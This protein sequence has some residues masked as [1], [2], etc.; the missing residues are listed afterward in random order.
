MPSTP[1]SELTGTAE[2]PIGGVLPNSISGPPSGWRLG[3]WSLIVTQFQGAFNDNALKF[4][5]IY[6]I[7]ER[8]FP[9]AMR[10]RLVL[11]V[12][13]L[14]ALPY[15]L[16]SLAGGYLADRYSKRSVTIG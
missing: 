13:A 14:F 7:V 3:F 16:F 15:I 5:V 2:A 11:L 4:L 12:G 1:Q 10:D 6:L 9:A 8:D